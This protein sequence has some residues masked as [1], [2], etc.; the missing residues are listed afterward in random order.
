M[1]FTLLFVALF[2]FI[3]S[4]HHEDTGPKIVTTH[5]CTISDVIFISKSIDSRDLKIIYKYE[6]LVKM[7]NSN[8][9]VILKNNNPSDY[10]ND[11][12]L[13]NETIPCYTVNIKNQ[14]GQE[15]KNFTYEDI[16]FKYPKIVYYNPK[17]VNY[18]TPNF[19]ISF[20]MMIFMGMI[21]DNMMANNLSF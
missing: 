3:Y 21:F 9:F 18:N 17:I 13:I 19:L 4:S 11:L 14:L 12:Q 16:S 15:N 8:S 2:S 1:I 20:I 6:I 10:S 5:E 7:N